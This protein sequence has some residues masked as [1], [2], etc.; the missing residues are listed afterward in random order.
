MTPRRIVMIN[1]A[2]SNVFNDSFEIVRPHDLRLICSQLQSFDEAQAIRRAAHFG[3]MM[4]R[5][6]PFKTN[7]LRTAIVGMI[8]MLEQEGIKVDIASLH[9]LLKHGVEVRS[10][11]EAI[12][13]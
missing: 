6:H 9:G 7:N 1:L 10:M 11:V 4:N 5:L 8:L 13:R 3:Y 2:L 12:T